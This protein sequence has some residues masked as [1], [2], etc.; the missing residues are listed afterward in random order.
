MWSP[1]S[2]A[3]LKIIASGLYRILAKNGLGPRA[4]LG[5]H[6]YWLSGSS[7]PLI[8]VYM[9]NWKITIFMGKSTISM[10]MFNSKLLVY[11]R[12]VSYTLW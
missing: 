9:T 7:H 12:V 10:A 4:Q 3:Q 1:E 8:N 5:N 2:P 11:Q 6:H